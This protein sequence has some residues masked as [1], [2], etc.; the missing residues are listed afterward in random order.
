[1]EA[2]ATGLRTAA[3]IAFMVL[4]GCGAPELHKNEAAYAPPTRGHWYPIPA[5]TPGH[6]CTRQDPDFDELRYQE[7]ISH[8]RR[9]VTKSTRIAVSEPYGVSED[10]LENYQVDHLIPLA[11]GGSNARENLWPVAYEQARA[12]ARFE[13]QTYLELKEGQIGQKA[14]VEKIRRWVR[15][16]LVNEASIR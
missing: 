8:C 11:L 16:N 7:Q 4:Y 15:D 3:F 2:R 6:L 5:L 10:E 13:Y 1:M 14:A 9:N 12:K